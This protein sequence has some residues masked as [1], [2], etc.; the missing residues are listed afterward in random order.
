MAGVSNQQGCT[1]TEDGQRLA[2]SDLGRREIYIQCSET[3]GADQPRGFRICKRKIFLRHGSNMD[4][5]LNYLPLHTETLDKE[6]KSA[7]VRAMC[8]VR[9]LDVSVII[10]LH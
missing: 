8:F 7:W 3:K 9:C 2:I 10:S 6:Q 5:I 4:I 1:N